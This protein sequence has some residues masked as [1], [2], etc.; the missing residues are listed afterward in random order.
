MEKTFNVTFTDPDDLHAV[1]HD[2]EVFGIKDKDEIIRV[3]EKDYEKLDNKP[4][5][6]SHTLIGDQTFDE[7]GLHR[8]TNWDIERMILLN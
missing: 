4:A 8:I 5:I 6:E 2:K 7:L 1:F 3:Y